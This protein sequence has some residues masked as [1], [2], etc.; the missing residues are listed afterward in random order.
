MH[1]IHAG[2]SIEHP[3]PA[4]CK[5]RRD[6]ERSR[7]ATGLHHPHRR[8]LATTARRSED[9]EAVIPPPSE[10]WE[11]RFLPSGVSASARGT[12]HELHGLSNLDANQQQSLHPIEDAL[13]NKGYQA[14]WQLYE[15][16]T[17]SEI[18][19]HVSERLWWTIAARTEIR[20]QGN[21][22]RLDD[23]LQRLDRI[24]RNLRD[25]YLDHDDTLK[26]HRLLYLLMIRIVNAKSS[27]RIGSQDAGPL[28]LCRLDGNLFRCLLELLRLMRAN[29]HLIDHRLLPRVVTA[30]ALAGRPVESIYWWQEQCR[31]ANGSNPAPLPTAE[32][33]EIWLDCIADASPWNQPTTAA[34]LDGPHEVT[35]WV[36]RII[37]M[38]MDAS[39]TLNK[40]PLTRW[41]EQLPLATLV[42]MLPKEVQDEMEAHPSR[43]A[44]RCSA[45]CDDTAKPTSSASIESLTDEHRYILV[46]ILAFHIARRGDVRPAL[47]LHRLGEPYSL[48]KGPI[49][50]TTMHSD[51]RTALLLAIA[52]F[53]SRVCQDTSASHWAIDD[54]KAAV[55][56]ALDVYAHQRKAAAAI[57]QPRHGFLLATNNIVDALTAVVMYDAQ[58]PLPP[59]QRSQHQDH[60]TRS[61]EWLDPLR[62]ITSS[63]LAKDPQI[64]ARSLMP[65][66]MVKLFRLHSTL[67]DYTFTRELWLK[68]QRLDVR[69]D[70]HSQAAQQQQTLWPTIPSWNQPGFLPLHDPNLAWLLR[71]TLSRPGTDNLLFAV[72][73]FVD[74]QTSLVASTDRHP[75]VPSYLC[76]K[77][78]RRLSQ[79]GLSHI[80]RG[81]V[82]DVQHS[83]ANITLSMS[84]ALTSAFQGANPFDAAQTLEIATN[85]I[86]LYREQEQEQQQQQQSSTATSEP[87]SRYHVPL[88]IFTYPVVQVTSSSFAQ[89][90]PTWHA[91]CLDLF[92]Q[93]AAELD[94]QMAYRASRPFNEPIVAPIKEHTIRTAFNGAIKTLLEWPTIHLFSASK[95]AVLARYRAPNE[96]ENPEEIE[97]SELRHLARNAVDNSDLIPSGSIEAQGHDAAEIGNAR[98][99]AIHQLNDVLTTRLGIQGDWE[100]WSLRLLAAMLPGTQ[101]Q[102]QKADALQVWEQSLTAEFDSNGSTEVKPWAR[103]SVQD[104]HNAP[105]DGQEGHAA[106]ANT[107]TADA[108]TQTPHADSTSLT[109]G[110]H[111]SAKSSEAIMR[112][113]LIRPAVAARFMLNLSL[114]G[115][116]A[117]ADAVYEGFVRKV[118]EVTALYTMEQSVAHHESGQSGKH[119]GN[120]P[121]RQE[122]WRAKLKVLGRFRNMLWE[123]YT[124]VRSRRSNEARPSRPIGSTFAAEFSNILEEGL[125]LM[126]RARALDLLWRQQDEGTTEDL[127]GQARRLWFECQLALREG[128]ALEDSSAA[129]Q[130]F[131]RQ[132]VRLDPRRNVVDK[133]TPV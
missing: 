66:T 25:E 74:W 58:Q 69:K 125:R 82:A 73:V 46:D 93:F 112:P 49:D 15:A 47:A 27:R 68:W 86:Q 52:R 2:P 19:R 124:V 4:R 113:V 44:L 89:W 79:A 33:I 51:T 105:G 102:Q 133:G 24:S 43:W 59:S 110:P 36:A 83:Q 16:S 107:A 17:P 35:S 103:F 60:A 8:F 37:T 129:W 72:D 115:D 70:L 123:N 6:V 18:P 99:A 85:I 130:R 53:A 128:R 38:A 34:G 106:G 67:G 108:T 10:H 5:T 97:S 121:E 56:V 62:S 75:L 127:A 119:P 1:N 7:H 78:L 98:R 40:R 3:S 111:R 9:A 14:A 21:N 48:H 12:S 26:C 94:K 101:K 22:R 23:D 96:S 131:E 77:L 29:R 65:S 132:A 100:T 91:R 95:R 80:I 117:A 13:D 104:L 118:E 50:H 31:L 116:P 126:K 114:D 30:M 81:I 87:N 41:M 63:I 11:T 92:Q 71:E 54:A 20:P 90:D 45:S 55:R 57:A 109:S 39:L 88:E 42:A 120:I 64:T 28:Y 122:Q 61:S 84:R 76:A 32:L